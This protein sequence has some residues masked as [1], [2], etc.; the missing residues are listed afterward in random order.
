M[1]LESVFQY[2]GLV[3]SMVFP[4]LIVMST[5]PWNFR[6]CIHNWRIREKR[7]FKLIAVEYWVFIFIMCLILLFYYGGMFEVVRTG[8]TYMGWN[9]SAATLII[10]ALGS[11]FSLYWVPMWF[12]PL[13]KR[14]FYVSHIQFIAL[15]FTVLGFVLSLDYTASAW[16][17]LPLC[18]INFVLWLFMW[19]YEEDHVT[20]FYEEEEVKK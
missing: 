15:F 13:R 4:M 9:T 19:K 8:G 11:F 20:L 6:E 18:I 17:M 16:F 14:D 3:A 5:L 1:G 2:V 10:A 12:V 7:Y